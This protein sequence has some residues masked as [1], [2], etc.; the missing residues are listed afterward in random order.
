MMLKE[1]RQL[2]VGEDYVHLEKY[3]EGKEPTEYDS[4]DDGFWDDSNNTEEDSSFLDF[5]ENG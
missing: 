3:W 5:F 1:K 2:E 4:A